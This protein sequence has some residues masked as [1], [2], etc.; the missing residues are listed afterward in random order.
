MYVNEEKNGLTSIPFQISHSTEIDISIH[1]LGI[2]IKVGRYFPIILLSLASMNLLLAANDFLADSLVFATLNS[3][4]ALGNF[5]SLVQLHQW[6]KTHLTQY[7][8]NQSQTD[9]V[10]VEG[11]GN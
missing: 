9:E 5:V 1:L 2:I 7:S 3:V 4:F 6:R 10:L 11:I 8:P